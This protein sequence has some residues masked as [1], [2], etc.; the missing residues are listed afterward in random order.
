MEELVSAIESA[1]VQEEIDIQIKSACLQ[2]EKEVKGDG[3]P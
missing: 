3:T 2:E 1:L